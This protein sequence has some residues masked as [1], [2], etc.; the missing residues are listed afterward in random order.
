MA[1]ISRRDKIINWVLI[2]S[3]I[4]VTVII[5]IFFGRLYS[6]M[7][8][9]L[10]FIILFIRLPKTPFGI[11]FTM[12]T[13]MWPYVIPITEDVISTLNSPQIT[14]SLD[15]MKATEWSEM[16]TNHALFKMFLLELPD[17]Y[18]F[19]EARPVKDKIFNNLGN[20]YFL[21]PRMKDECVNCTYYFLQVKNT[22]S[23]DLENLKITA[24]FDETAEIIGWDEKITVNEGEGF[25]S[26][27]RYL[28]SLSFLNIGETQLLTFRTNN[29]NLPIITCEKDYCRDDM[30]D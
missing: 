23:E 13:L 12:I 9:M 17:Y 3:F 10:F 7:A 29:E 22:G 18:I 6:I 15:R 27:G 14:I 16:E 28:I 30:R 1:N 25:F 20:Y 19:Y 4:I 5:Y 8:S 11:F 2:V 21:N 24:Q 26:T